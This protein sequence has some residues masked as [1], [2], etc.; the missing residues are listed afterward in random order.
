MK[1]AG[2]AGADGGKEWSRHDAGTEMMSSRARLERRRSERECL[3]RG[4]ADDA[5][6]SPAAGE[7][8]KGDDAEEEADDDDGVDGVS[9]EAEREEVE[10]C[11]DAERFSLLSARGLRIALRLAFF[12]LAFFC[13]SSSLLR[14]KMN[15]SSRG[16]S[17][18]TYTNM[19]I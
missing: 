17:Y 9:R 6:P 12:L 11:R 10:L 3:R 2:S 15:R 5:S 19:Y 4:L 7:E 1:G 14:V 13:A 18:T 16:S 8:E